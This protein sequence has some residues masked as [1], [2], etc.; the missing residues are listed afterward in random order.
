M[1][2]RQ[3]REHPHRLTRALGCTGESP[4]IPQGQEHNPKDRDPVIGGSAVVHWHELGRK[5][6]RPRPREGVILFRLV[7]EQG[8]QTGAITAAESRMI[9]DAAQAADM[10][11]EE[12]GSE[13]LPWKLL[14]VDPTAPS[15]MGPTR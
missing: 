2:Q 13:W 9:T 15:R 7:E 6:W 11:P 8:V 4:G 3:L 12:A 14:G 5:G 10:I 1:R